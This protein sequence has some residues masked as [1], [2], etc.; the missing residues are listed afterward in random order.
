MSSNTDDD[1]P[2]EKATGFLGITR[3]WW[4]LI[5]VVVIGYTFGKDLALT[6]N[7]ADQANTVS[8]DQ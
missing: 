3:Y 1:A 2:K 6:H 4:I 5:I 8:T 7:E